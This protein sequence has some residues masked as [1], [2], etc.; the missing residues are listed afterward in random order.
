MSS[1]GPAAAGPRAPGPAAP[2]P[3]ADVEQPADARALFASFAA[4]TGLEARFEEQKHLAL[5]AAPLTGGGRL[6]FMPPGHLARVVERP[7][8]SVVTISPTELRMS[9]KDGVESV[10]LRM[11]ADVRLFV[12]S[13]V[14]VFSGD[15][16]VLEQSYEVQFE[17]AATGWTLTLTPRALPLSEMLAELRLRGSGRAVSELQIREPNGDRT[18]TRIL[19]ADTARRFSAEEQAELFGIPP[20]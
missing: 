11:N 13:L 18:V 10:D 7:E 6:Y 16:A 17:S 19:E 4:M 15:A 20:R 12:T 3:A 8:R 14:R 1:P 5:L 2:T 9:G